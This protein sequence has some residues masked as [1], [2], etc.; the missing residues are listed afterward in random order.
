MEDVLAV[1]TRPR[2]GDCPLVCL[3]ETGYIVS[4]NRPE[5]ANLSSWRTKTVNF[6]TAI[7][8]QVNKDMLRVHHD[9]L[10]FPDG[11]YVLLTDLREG[12]SSP[13]A[14]HLRGL[15]FAE[16]APITASWSSSWFTARSPTDCQPGADAKKQINKK[17]GMPPWRQQCG[18]LL[19]RS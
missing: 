11:T 13:E 14:R 19:R 5:K 12:Q 9:A 6:R 4:Q 18:F 7:F 8:R 1:Y 3:D 2:D 17:A 16:S 15:K 10:E